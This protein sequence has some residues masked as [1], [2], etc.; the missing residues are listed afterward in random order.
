MTNAE[1]PSMPGEYLRSYDH[2]D[3]TGTLPGKYE[4]VLK[5]AAEVVGVEEEEVGRAVEVLE[6]R[7]ERVRK[8][9]GE[10]GWSRHTS[11][12][13]GRERSGSRE[14]TTAEG[15]R[16]RSRARGLRKRASIG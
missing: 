2:T 16:S 12:E 14:R 5:A 8:E 1:L 9:R 3:L 13:R 6:R 4:V 7:L 10:R 15:S 11:R